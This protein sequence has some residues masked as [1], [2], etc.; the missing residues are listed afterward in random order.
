MLAD[1]MAAMEKEWRLTRG[2]ELLAILRPDGRRLVTDHQAVEGLFKTTT[3]FEPLRHF[4]EREMELLDVD[5]EPENSEWAAIW[6][7]LQAPG[8]FVE[9]VDGRN[10]IDILWI[11]FKDRRAWWFPLY[12]SPHTLLRTSG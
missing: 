1:R 11:H 3:A 10:R 8:L 12:N 5:R 4:F 2:G 6:E 7:E 9:S